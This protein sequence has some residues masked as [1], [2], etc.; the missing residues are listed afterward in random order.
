VKHN[1]R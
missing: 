1:E